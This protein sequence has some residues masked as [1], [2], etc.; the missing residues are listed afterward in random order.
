[1]S[2]AGT[3]DAERGSTASGT[4]R[5]LVVGCMSGTSLDA[6]D[7]ALVEVVG[8][9]LGMR[10]RLLGTSSK[11]LG[12]LADRLRLLA[13]GGAMRASEVAD[14]SHQFALLHVDVIR[15]LVTKLTHLRVDLICVHGQTVFHAPPLSW[16]VL[17]PWPIV[18]ALG[19][20][21]VFDLRGADLAHGGQGAPITPIAD[22]LLLRDSCAGGPVAVVNLGGFA[23]FTWLPRAG[24]SVEEGLTQV[25]GGDLCVC[26][27]LL[28]RLARTRLGMAFDPNGTQ[29]LRGQIHADARDALLLHL[30]RTGTGRSLGSGDEAFG[31]LDTHA[32]GL[33]PV[34]ACATA[35]DAI[36][37]F[38]AARLPDA[39][40]VALAGGGA[41]NLALTGAIRRYL[42]RRSPTATLTDLDALGLSGASREALEFGVL[43]AL[44]EDGVSISLPSITG[45]SSPAPLAG[46]WCRPTLSQE[47]HR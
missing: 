31:W 22:Y 38:L 7:A 46:C 2:K 24:V 28:D 34:D 45:V 13:D 21:V 25:R 19:S 10:C 5:R 40:V 9:G 12:S 16:Q 32:Q 42:Q 4:C 29:A 43:G 30:E 37:A 6:I 47:T 36:G 8:R 35:C 44:C 23:N 14:V 41:R 3:S 17:N 27:Q 1:M 39:S 11:P 18:R 33:Q 20:P 15:S 26:N